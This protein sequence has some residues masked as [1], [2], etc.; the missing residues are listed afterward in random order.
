MELLVD[1]VHPSIE[2]KLAIHQ[3]VSREHCECPLNLSE[4]GRIQSMVAENMCCYYAN[5]IFC[6]NERSRFECAFHVEFTAF[7]P[8]KKKPSMVVYRR[9]DVFQCTIQIWIHGFFP[10]ICM[11]Q[12]SIGVDLL[13]LG[14]VIRM[15]L[16]I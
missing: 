7:I 11:Q 6:E 8:M 13:L 9:Y 3:N 15:I 16:Q 14:N 5:N 1:Y 4:C 10:D 2:E 12:L